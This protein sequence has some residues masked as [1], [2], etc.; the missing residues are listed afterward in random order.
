MGWWVCAVKVICAG[1]R[2][3][4]VLF[5]HILF[6]NSSWIYAFQNISLLFN[7]A[8]LKLELLRERELREA[9]EKQL[10]AEQKRL[11]KFL[12]HQVLYQELYQ[13]AF[14]VMPIR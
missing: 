13:V 14:N 5:L 2:F 6:F 4:C 3:V 11:G 10:V 12:S 9:L 7:T 8:E 1:L